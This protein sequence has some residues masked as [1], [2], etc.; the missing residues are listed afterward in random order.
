MSQFFQE[1]KRRKVL[2]TLG[3]Y[4]AA[5]IVI[6]QLAASI[7]PFLY[8]PDWTVTLV[9]VLV[10]LGFPITFFL[11]WTY[12]LKRENKTDNASKHEDVN[13]DKKWSITKKILFPVTGFILMLIGGIFWFVYPF[14]TLGLGDDREYDASIAILYMANISPEEKSYFA[15]G[16]TEEL[17]TRLSRIQNLKVR[18]RTDVAAFKNKQIKMDEIAKQLNVNYIVEGSVKII[19]ENLRVNIS[20]FDIAKDNSIWSESYDNTLKDILNVQ[21]DI[22][23]SIVN[24]LN[25]KLTITKSD[26]IATEQ[27][28]TENLEAYNL[29]MKAYQHIN[30]PIYTQRRLQE[31]IAPLAQRAI[32]LDSTYSDAY[33]I[34]ALAKLYKWMDRP[35]K[36]GSALREEEIKDKAMGIFHANTAL[37]YDE[38][39]ILA[40][41][42]LIVISTMWDISYELSETQKII[43]ARNMV[44]ETKRLLNKYPDDIFCQT[45]YAFIQI[46]KNYMINADDEAYQEPLDRMLKVHQK[47]KHNNF[48]YN[49][50][51]EQMAIGLIFEN[52]PSLYSR[53][54]KG[55]KGMQF[56][57]DNKHNFCADRTYN[58]LNAGI[59]TKIGHG[60]YFSNDYEN[61]LEIINMILS[62]SEEDLVSVGNTIEA[63]ILP[64]YRSGM[65]Y[66]KWGEYDNAIEGFTEALKLS[67]ENKDDNQFWEGHYYQR[68]GLVYFFKGDYVNASENYLE[69]FKLYES[70]ED[71]KK[72]SITSLCSYGYVEEL[73]GNHE[74]A[75]EKMD[76]CANWVSENPEKESNDYPG[77][78]AYQRIWPL[79]LYHKNIN[80]LD[81]ASN[82]LTMAYETI[83]K[84]AK[85]KY[86]KH[87]EKDTHPEFFYCRDIIKEYEASLNQ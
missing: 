7:F 86:H 29:I 54:G 55:D 84:K 73:L 77:S 67:L 3:V 79:Y 4:G 28:S 71:Y 66:M 43:N 12:D 30:N 46:K 13:K 19:D 27:K 48:V 76:E 34:S 26:L 18:P 64:Y 38:N 42:L 39:N 2:K 56:T 59:L 65:I 1:L 51:T 22:A 32:E 23:S 11:S 21:D 47:L 8:L 83:G 69:S 87:P 57:K 60:F 52:V 74:L 6:T 24:K 75:K 37:Y 20:L 40:S 63:K 17:I 41:V 33:A 35:T 15:D 9:I 78:E 61:A 45:V 31:I 70:I 36:E 10:S 50:P 49:H 85:D 62:Q 68:L 5:A 53:L 82:Y 58:C 80:I 81:K 16:L 14:L 44:I 72:H 25:K